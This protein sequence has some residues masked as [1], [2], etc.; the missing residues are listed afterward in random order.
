MQ[1]LGVQPPS[2]AR[3][4]ALVGALQAARDAGGSTAAAATDGDAGKVPG[5]ETATMVRG[6]ETEAPTA[7]KAEPKQQVAPPALASPSLDA[8]KTSNA[9]THSNV[10]L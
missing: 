7:R 10:H 6:T 4:A 3:K 1:K 9:S 8:T 5:A 2:P